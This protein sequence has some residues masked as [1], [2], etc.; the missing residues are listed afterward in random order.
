M[1]VETWLRLYKTLEFCY[2]DTENCGEVIKVMLLSEFNSVEVSIVLNGVRRAFGLERGTQ[3][4]WCHHFS[5]WSSPINSYIFYQRCTIRKH[6]KNLKKVTDRSSG[7]TNRLG[8]L[9]S[10]GIPSKSKT[11]KLSHGCH[12]IFIPFEIDESIAPTGL[13]SNTVEL[14]KLWK[15]AA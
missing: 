14:S 12:C 11:L 6:K 2:C 7:K 10:N 8:K 3:V 9:N 1:P 4:E 15:V 13:E 5:Y